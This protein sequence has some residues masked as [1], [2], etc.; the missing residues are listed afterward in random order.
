MGLLSLFSR[1]KPASDN[2]ADGDA[3]DSVARAR[4]RARQRLLGAVVLVGIGIV[5][6]PLLFE[7]EP[8]PI[9]VDVP[10]EIPARDAA[11]PLTLPGARDAEPT[12]PSLGTAAPAG[13]SES[14]ITESAA[15]AGKPVVSADK[16]AP[17]EK[18][19][20]AEK[21]PVAERPSAEAGAA[22]A[23]ARATEKAAADKAAADKAAE[24]AQDKANEKAAAQAAEAARARA[25]LEGKV[26]PKVAADATRYIVQIGAFADPELA[27]A[28]RLKV[29]RLGLTTYTHVAKT[30][31]GERTRVRVGPVATRDEAE[32]IAAK[33]KA[34]GLPTA[35]LTL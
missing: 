1:S 17:A 7:T 16:A 12:P 21:A 11:A 6:F 13:R 3:G 20:P 30:A 10:I 4:T 19:Q 33:I 34:A 22:A 26:T 25:L 14:I 35:I 27:R 28:T 24:R 5:G 32:K 15:D 9:P 8:R 23:T 2:A 18:P 29:E 31:E